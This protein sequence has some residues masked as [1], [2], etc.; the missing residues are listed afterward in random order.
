MSFTMFNFF[1]T[2]FQKR[3]EA[4]R[5]FI[6]RARNQ[7]GNFSCTIMDKKD[8]KP[9]IAEGLLKN[10][11][12]LE[13]LEIS[14][15]VWA[16]VPHTLDSEVIRA[17]A[18]CLTQNHNLL[19]LS[20]WHCF[21]DGP[22]ELLA[23]GLAQN[24]SLITLKLIDVRG[25]RRVI[26]KGLHCPSLEC[27]SLASNKLNCDDARALAQSQLP[28]LTLLNLSSN[29][30]DFAGGQVIGAWLTQLPAFTTLNFG[31]N[32]DF[33]G[34][35]NDLV[36][37]PRL[38]VLELDEGFNVMRFD[39][40]A[41]AGWLSHCRALTE[42]SLGECTLDEAAG[43]RVQALADVLAQLPLTKLNLDTKSAMG[44]TGARAFGDLLRVHKTL[45]KLNL[46]DT[47]GVGD[48]GVRALA[49]G[50]AHSLSLR[51]LKLKIA[52]RDAWTW[53]AC[54]AQN[55]GL[56]ELNF[57]DRWARLKESSVWALAAGLRRNR[58]LVTLD[59]RAFDTDEAGLRS[60]RDVLEEN[61]KIQKIMLKEGNYI[62]EDALEERDRRIRVRGE[63][64]SES[65]EALCM[66]RADGVFWPK[67]FPVEVRVKVLLFMYES[68]KNMR[69]SDGS[70]ERYLYKLASVGG[71]WTEPLIPDSVESP[72]PTELILDVAG[73]KEN[74]VYLIQEQ[75][76]EQKE[77]IRLLQV[78]NRV[79]KE[80]IRIIQNQA[81]GANQ[82]TF[83][84]RAQGECHGEDRDQSGDAP[85]EMHNK[86]ESL[87]LI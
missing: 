33:S 82:S 17:L 60:L 62:I 20:L 21:L 47:S 32:M 79:L 57:G 87:E 41:F 72:P 3:R 39:H 11:T 69:G 29:S 58:T 22:G 84:E 51:S 18:T 67:N 23:A 1:Q 48:I 52:D 38:T 16:S 7:D 64:W 81:V 36:R 49:N 86:Q 68:S 54:F 5:E 28:A 56:T 43:F 14:L 83:Q 8:V 74:N 50:V 35:T 26:S 25:I 70:T 76:Q 63:V 59:M 27:L 44:E 61:E 66:L 75:L 15:E 2:N 9:F 12:G 42:L 55:R 37:V 31:G 24:R 4:A 77:Q 53:A 71:I 19:H 45:T 85:K 73:L 65:L 78:E 10:E 80:E 13:E 34:V 6:T 46:G 40:Q 30:I